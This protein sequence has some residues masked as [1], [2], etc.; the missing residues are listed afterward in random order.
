M[1][2]KA[3]NHELACKTYVAIL[4][5]MARPSIAVTDAT[6]QKEA[7]E[8]TGGAAAGSTDPTIDSYRGELST[9][10]F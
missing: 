3:S 8:L 4:E 9:A 5:L 7:L 1:R 2:D 6:A 10:V